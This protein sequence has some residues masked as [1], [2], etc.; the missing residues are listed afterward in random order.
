MKKT[1][2][3]RA[4]ALAEGYS[5]S[6]FFFQERRERRRRFVAWSPNLPQ[7]KLVFYHL[8]RS[9]TE[10]VEVL[11]KVAE[12]A[13]DSKKWQKF[14]GVSSLPNLQKVIG[15][16]EKVVFQDGGGQLSI[17][18]PNTDE[19]ITLDEHGVLYVYSSSPR[20]KK[21]F[22]QYGFGERREKLISDSGHWHISPS[23]AEKLRSDLIKALNL[24]KIDESLSPL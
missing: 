17:K 6:P 8:L 3:D 21:L 9:F 14:H 24:K 7:L 22:I 5:P 20:L 11:F 16:N 23:G 12:N 13:S 18:N 19:Y 1:L 4:K 15:S 10:N 2:E